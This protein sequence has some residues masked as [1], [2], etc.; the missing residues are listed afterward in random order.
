MARSAWHRAGT[1][2]GLAVS[3]AAV[4]WLLWRYDWRG[5]GDALAAAHWALFVPVPLVMIANFMLR[6]ARWQALFPD[7][8][9]PR[10]GGS[11]VALMAG[12]L[13]NNVL[14]ARAGE[15][16]RVHMIGRREQLPRSTA[17]GTVVLE[18]TLDLLVLLALFAFV[19]LNQPLPGW[20]AHA[21]RMVAVLA[22]GAL[23]VILFLGWQGERLVESIVPRLGFLPAA[24]TRRLD[25]SGRAFIGGVSAVLRA[26]HLAR[27]AAFTILIWS[28]EVAT[29]WLIARAF[30]LALGPLDVLFVMLA[31]TLGTMVPASP[32]YV[33]TFEF[34][35]LSALQLI[36]IS[37]AAALGFV[38]TLHAAV[39]LGSSLIGAACLA[40]QGGASFETAD[41]GQG[42]GEQTR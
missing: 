14:P 5:V 1:W 12:Y 33:G 6:A 32:G 26:S 36:G 4:A 22:L 2:L 28:L 20:T 40:W 39:L 18:R 15:L 9:R 21:G 25:A 42:N 29:V 11:F 13:F 16:V 41:D 31:I 34:F 35:G 27:F 24:V 23:G 38:V 19:L 3:A 30:A 8:L 10:F 17:L 7:D 37:G